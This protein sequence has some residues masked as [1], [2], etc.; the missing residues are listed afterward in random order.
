MAADFVQWARQQLFYVDTTIVIIG[1]HFLMASELQGTVPP[2]EKRDIYNVFINAAP[3]PMDNLAACRTYAAFDI[4]PT[5]LESI[6]ANLP[7]ARFALG[8]SLFRSEST[9]AEQL[10]MVELNEEL[11]ARSPFYQQFFGLEGIAGKL[12][13]R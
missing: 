10:G 3:P 4:A 13:L 12:L 5:L 2:Y 6:G 11:A 1:D 9:L 8:R 7:A